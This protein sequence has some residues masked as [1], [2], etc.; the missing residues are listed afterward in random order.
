MNN[1]LYKIKNKIPYIVHINNTIKVLFNFDILENKTRQV[2]ITRTKFTA[3]MTVSATGNL[4]VME[5]V[6]C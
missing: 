2:V 5:L 3:K 4:Y 1:L 6:Y